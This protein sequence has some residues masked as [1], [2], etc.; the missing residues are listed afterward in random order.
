M[1]IKQRLFFIAGLVLI[2]GCAKNG[3]SS[4]SS[5]TNSRL[6]KKKSLVSEQEAKLS[7]L[8][9]PLDASVLKTYSSEN[10][11]AYT[12]RMSVPD[13]AQFIEEEMESHGWKIVTKLVEKEA[14]LVFEKP[15]KYSTV[16]IRPF[17]GKTLAIFFNSNK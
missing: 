9:V 6:I 8:A 16:S 17:S 12:S 3:S 1:F 11:Y 15:F 4:T 7:D 2:S 10:S 5:K 14:S 13:L